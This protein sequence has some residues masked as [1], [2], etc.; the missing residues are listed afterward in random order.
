LHSPILAPV[1]ALVVSSF[2][3]WAWLYATRIPAVLKGKIA[4]GPTRSKEEFDAPLPA[5]VRWKAHNLARRAPGKDS[6]RLDRKTATRD[7]DF[8][9]SLVA[10]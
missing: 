5:K 2:V 4:L 7:G 9:A 8:F 10:A 3:M 1:M 6:V